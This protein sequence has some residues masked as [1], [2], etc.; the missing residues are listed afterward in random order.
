LKQR[1]A[2]IGRTWKLKSI[3]F[4]AVSLRPVSG[5]HVAKTTANNSPSIPRADPAAAEVLE[6]LFASIKP[7][8]PTPQRLYKGT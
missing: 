1:S 2:K 6:A 3:L 5:T 8:V 4:V 7:N